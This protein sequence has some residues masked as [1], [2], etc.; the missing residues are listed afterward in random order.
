MFCWNPLSEGAGTTIYDVSWNWNHWTA[1]NTTEAS[2]WGSTQ[3]LYHYNLLNG[4]RQSWNVKIPALVDGSGAADGNAITNPAGDR[5]NGA[6][7]K[8]KAPET[9]EL[10]QA[11]S[12]DDFRFDA[13]W[14]AQAKWYTD[15]VDDV[16]DNHVTLADVSTTNQKKNIVTYDSPRTSS[17]TPTLGDVQT[18]LNH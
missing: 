12:T 11:D 18:L 3:D 7:T 4:F 6:E 15:I 10:I 8:L 16:N 13:S 9:P 1:V 14:V 17:T 5:H 2:F